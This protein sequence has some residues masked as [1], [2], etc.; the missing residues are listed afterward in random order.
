MS[1]NALIHAIKLR[2]G[3]DTG[4]HAATES[5]DGPIWLHFNVAG[6][7]AKAEIKAAAPYID[8]VMIDALCATDTRPRVEEFEN[9]YLVILRGI[10]LNPEED[11]EDM[12]SLRI[13][14]DGSHVISAQRRSV[15]A[16]RKLAAKLKAEETPASSSE[17]IVALTVNIIDNMAAPIAEIMEEID[18]LE[19]EMIDGG[20]T[21]H[22]TAL[23]DLR[24]KVLLLRRYFNP[25]RAAV[26][27]LKELAAT[28]LGEKY[29]KRLRNAHDD[30]TRHLEDLDTARDRLQ[31]QQEELVTVLSDRLNRNMYTLSIVAAIFLPLG[32][33][34][35]LFGINV[36]G[37]PGVEDTTAFWWV[38]G[39]CAAIAGVLA[40][41][42]RRSGWF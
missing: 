40:L 25:L 10:N 22:R 36:G 18:E 27:V 2:D 14:S 35:G 29:T 16:A 12:V 5:K 41:F 6:P 42:F 8:D 34:T 15:F 3:A 11:P 32:F 39:G 31:F 21:E 7:N 20:K 24:H 1:D 19:L 26:G 33:L 4:R 38:C 17:V 13:W 30:L 28:W 37:M 23:A 9:E